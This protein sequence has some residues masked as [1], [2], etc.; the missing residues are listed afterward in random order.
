MKKVIILILY[1]FFL[2]SCQEVSKSIEDTF[3]PK[4]EVKTESQAEKQ[5]APSPYEAA[6]EE[7]IKQIEKQV[8]TIVESHTTTHV[9]YHKEGKNVDFLTNESKLNEAET[10]LKKLPQ[11]AG[12][13]IF[14]YSSIHFYNDGS[15]SVMLQHPQNTKYVDSYEYKQGKWS[16]P[17]PKLLSVRDNIQSRMISLN[18]IRFSNVSAIT[19]T[20][21]EKAMQIE[22]AKPTTSVYISIWDNRMRWFPSSINGSRERYAIEFSPDGTLKRFEQE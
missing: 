4:V 10:A 14:I 1:S 17:T 22:G 13:E 9:Q 12:K 7:Q 15:I 5:P 19:N 20:Y 11:Y 8:T 3:N 16:E 18:S 21:N 6:V 2:M